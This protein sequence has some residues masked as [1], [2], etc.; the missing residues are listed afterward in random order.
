MKKQKFSGWSEWLASAPSGRWCRWCELQLPGLCLRHPQVSGLGCL[1]TSQVSKLGDAFLVSLW[2]RQLTRC[3]FVE[4]PKVST[5]TGDLGSGWRTIWQSS[6]V[7]ELFFFPFPSGCA[8]AAEHLNSLSYFYPGCYILRNETRRKTR[9]REMV[10]LGLG[11][12]SSGLIWTTNSELRGSQGVAARQV[13]RIWDKWSKWLF[14]ILG[15]HSFDFK[16]I[17]HLGIGAPSDL[18]STP[19]AVFPEV[20]YS[21]ANVWNY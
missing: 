21:L 15:F 3:V 17:T 5:F 19:G 12:L 4:F 13:I 8:V 16:P 6:S 11:M 20:A 1:K 18:C 2:G 7:R 9:L 10:R 14:S